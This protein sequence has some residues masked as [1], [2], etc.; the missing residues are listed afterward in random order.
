MSV[1]SE[2]TEATNG[3]SIF[4][5]DPTIAMAVPPEPAPGLAVSSRQ[6][7]SGVGMAT[8]GYSAA[9]SHDLPNDR[10]APV[11]MVHEE[12][13]SG[14]KEVFRAAGSGEDFYRKQKQAHWKTVEVR[15]N[16]SSNSSNSGT[17]SDGFGADGFDVPGQ[18]G[19][20]PVVGAAR[21]ARG[22]GG[23]AGVEVVSG[24]GGNAVEL[25][26]SVVEKGT[27]RQTLQS[28]STAAVSHRGRGRKEVEKEKEEE[29]RGVSATAEPGDKE[30]PLAPTAAIDTNSNR[31]GYSLKG[32]V[33]SSV[34]LP[35]ITPSDVRGSV[36]GGRYWGGG[37]KVD[38]KEKDGL[39]FLRPALCF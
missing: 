24:D 35:C 5:T 37:V 11:S 3:G 39:L 26:S 38:K 14:K 17:T 34:C 21:M 36:H 7:V 8:G 22:G 2:S 12:D 10:P 29:L 23:G 31:T 15:G 30:T 16:S 18:S 1:G 33:V 6:D 25:V 28:S 9:S 19:G 4:P 13:G 27:S 32:I 20:I